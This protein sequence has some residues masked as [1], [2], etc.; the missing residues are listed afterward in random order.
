[1][2]G[3]L[4]PREQGGEKKGGQEPEVRVSAGPDVGWWSQEADLT[5]GSRL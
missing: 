5:G 1:M 3:R 2:L 4:L